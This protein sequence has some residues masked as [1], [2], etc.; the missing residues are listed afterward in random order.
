MSRLIMIYRFELPGFKCSPLDC[1][2]IS[3]SKITVMSFWRLMIPFRI[4]KR[5]ILFLLLLFKIS[6]ATC[7]PM[8][9]NPGLHSPWT[10]S[11]LDYILQPHSS[12]SMSDNATYL[13]SY[14]SCIYYELQYS[15]IHAAPISKMNSNVTAHR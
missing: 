3:L 11:S 1:S 8:F 6:S 14:C 4:E 12:N 10:T 7:D 2:N 9:G 5:F 15:G 13:T